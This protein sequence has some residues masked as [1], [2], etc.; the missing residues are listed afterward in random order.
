MLRALALIAAVAL[1]ACGGGGG[2]VPVSVQ[3][4]GKAVVGSTGDTFVLRL[5]ENPT[6]GYSWSVTTEPDTGVVKQLSSAYTPG[7]TGVAGAE[8]VREWRF[9]AVAPGRTELTMDYVRP[10]GDEGPANTYTVTFEVQ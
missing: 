9:E 3:D 2:E 1:V 10:F 8:G 5:G 4:N 6:T 7:E